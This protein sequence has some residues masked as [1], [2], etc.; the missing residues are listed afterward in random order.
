M[1]TSLVELLA[2]SAPIVADGGMGTMLFRAGL[3]RGTP[4][5]LW[6]VERPE[7]VRSIH[8]GYIAAGAQIILTNSFGGNRI[9]LGAHGLENCVGELNQ[10]AA[11]L[12]GQEADRAEQPVLVAGSIGPTGVLM[13]PLGDL[14]AE[15]AINAFEEQARALVAGGVDALWIE[16]MSDLEEVRA[17]VTGCHRASD[18]VPIV[19]TM[20]FDTKGRTMMGVTP[21]QAVKALSEMGI[22]AM[23]ANCG[24]GPAEIEGVI[25]K[26]HA[27]N[28]GVALVA[29][30]NAGIPKVFDNELFYDATP[31]IMKDYARRVL[32]LGARVVG[33]CCGSTPDHIRA[34][35]E[36][37]REPAG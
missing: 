5:E 11:Q 20:T 29:K 26:M 2:G 9:R 7:A 18:S 21:E 16:T 14:T 32:A 19:T 3:V 30:S 10:S 24:N 13:E 1:R 17:A 35:A 4:P 34:I 23:G 8:A 33:A 27:A 6:N 15:G 31:D 36:S 25:A 37:I 22:A 28:A 12:A